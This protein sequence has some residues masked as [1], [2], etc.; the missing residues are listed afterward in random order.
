MK[1]SREWYDL[2][3]RA[4]LQE[5]RQRRHL[6]KYLKYTLPVNLKDAHILDLCC[7]TGEFARIAADSNPDSRIVG[8]D[9]Y[10]PSGLGSDRQNLTF[11]Q[12][13]AFDI[14]AEDNTFDHLFCFHSLHHLGEV[15]GWEELIHEMSRVLK[16]GGRLHLI[17]HYPGIWLKLA[18]QFFKTTLP[19]FIP[20][21]RDFKEQ[22]YDERQ[23]LGYWLDHWR[24]FLKM[25]TENRFMC[26]ESRKGIFFFYSEYEKVNNK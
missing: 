19:V 13:S 22:L 6:K 23:I 21:M 24:I 18:L 8:M 26:T 14:A 20:W 4:A 17:D 12:S 2:Y 1:E 15:S 11:I 16:P 25:L 10:F 9:V 5:R 3:G 7:G